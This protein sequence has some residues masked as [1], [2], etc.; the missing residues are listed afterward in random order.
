M[1]GYAISNRHIR[2]FCTGM[3]SGSFI[4][5]WSDRRFST[6]KTLLTMGLQRETAGRGAL[7]IYTSV[8]PPSSHDLTVKVY[9]LWPLQQIVFAVFFE[10][11]V[12]HTTPSTL[13]IIGALMIVGSAIYTTVIFRVSS[14]ADLMLTPTQL[15]KQKTTV[16][17]ASGATPEQSASGTSAS[18]NDDDPEA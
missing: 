11:V 16:K 10:F 15:T 1:A 4:T 13:S 12:F 14:P 18:D 7:A 9:Q 8:C 2:F 3:P 6:Y 5:T 17:P